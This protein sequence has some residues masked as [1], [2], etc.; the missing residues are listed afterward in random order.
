LKEWVLSESK[1]V[2]LP[3]P[4]ESEAAQILEEAGCEIVLCP[5]PSPET[6]LPLMSGVQGLILRTG[7]RITRQLLFPADELCIISRTGGGLDNVDVEAATEKEII[8]TSNVGVNTSS[9]VEH[10]LALMLALCKQ[11]PQMDRAV[12]DERFS[13]RYK[14]LPRDLRKKTLG[15]MG[16]GRIGSEVGRVCHHLFCM[17][18]LAFD[19]LLPEEIKQRS[20][21]WV[22]FVEP[23]ALFSRSDVIS[24]HA[25]LTDQTHHAVGEREIAWMKPEAILINTSRG[26]V[27]D[28]W[29]LIEAL[30]EGR[31]G[32][33]G[34]DVFSEEP[35]STDNPL[36]GLDNVI[37]TPHTAALTRE[38][39]IRMATEAARCVVDCFNGVEPPNVANRQVLGSKRWRHLKSRERGVY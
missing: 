8:V 39:V 12:R 24:I 7:I 26:P 28:E 27:I 4:I 13:I 6:V 20:G 29:A 38:C 37:L 21:D 18:I 36:L 17:K 2:L 9:V 22:T 1:R 34:L 16:F 19:P 14:N 31:I 35:V 3:Q 25:P 5:D 33:A 32:G 30:K 11:L 23:Q 15:L 10:A